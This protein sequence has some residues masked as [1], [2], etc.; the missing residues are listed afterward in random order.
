MRRLYL[1]AAALLTAAFIAGCQPSTKQVSA[2]GGA[3]GE[4]AVQAKSGFERADAA[5]V[6]RQ[7]LALAGDPTRLPT[8]ADFKGLATAK[9]LEPR[10]EV[11]EKLGQYANALKALSDADTRSDVDAASTDLYSALDGL[12]TTYG[13]LPDS[14]GQPRGPLFDKETLGLIATV[15]DATGVAINEIKKTT[16]LKRVITLADDGVKNACGALAADLGAGGAFSQ[17]YANALN[18]ARTELKNQYSRLNKDPNSTFEARMRLL[19]QLRDAY[20][21][22]EAGQG[23]TA[24]MDQ[25]IAAVAKSHHALK[26]AVTRDVFTTNDVVAAVNELSKQVQAVRKFRDGLDKTK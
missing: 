18:T 4:L 24:S 19:D 16:A 2:F 6:R 1:V 10:M 12:S 3:T 9:Q 14:S 5:V 11:L 17:G 7:L 22:F 21:D 8:D 23:L 26:D 13:K 15:V 25:A 20:G